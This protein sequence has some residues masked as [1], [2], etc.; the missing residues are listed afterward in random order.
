MKKYKVLMG[1]GRMASHHPKKYIIEAQDP[2]EAASIARAQ[3]H[4][5]VGAEI[6]RDAA[7]W[8]KILTVESVI[9]IKQ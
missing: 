2:K 4:R 7:I 6:G 9:E 5:D 8:G 3:Y 1:L